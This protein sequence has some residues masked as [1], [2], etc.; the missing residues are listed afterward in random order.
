MG[1]NQ[2]LSIADSGSGEAVTLGPLSGLV[3]YHLRRA[4]NAFG[5]DFSRA[6]T[7]TGMRQV[8]LAI[9]SV[10]ASNPRANQGSVGR[11]LGIQRANMVALINDLVE[12]GLIDRQVAQG[13]RRAFAL[14]ITAEGRKLLDQCLARI[15]EHEAE[16]LS[17]L[18]DAERDMLIDLLGRIEAKE[19]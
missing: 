1:T 11:V 13:D 15:A 6:L 17:D 4:S 12:R 2:D 5:A 7:G 9:L 18:S 14:T 10:V 8:L 19:R 3:G 16:M